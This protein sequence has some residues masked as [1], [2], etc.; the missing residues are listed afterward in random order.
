[1]R[2]HEKTDDDVTEFESYIF[3]FKCIPNKT[4]NFDVFRLTNQQLTDTKAESIW[5]YYR[6][7]FINAKLTGEGLSSFRKTLQKFIEN[8]PYQN[9]DSRRSDINRYIGLARWLELQYNVD[10]TIDQLSESWDKQQLEKASRRIQ[11]TVP[12]NNYVSYFTKDAHSRL[13]DPKDYDTRKLLVRNVYAY[14]H[15]QI[16][17]YVCASEYGAVK[18]W[19]HTKHNPFIDWFEN[20]I[21]NGVEINVVT[22]KILC[23]ID[24]ST[25]Y[26][27]IDNF[28]VD[29]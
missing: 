29:N 1:M 26:I 21:N 10:T 4:S 28:F 2:D 15:K 5:E 14:T 22:S 27:K 13:K 8:K 18:V 19:V 16:R 3:K 6:T 11:G 12:F 20:R 23:N 9:D 25:P 7:L 17:W 24:D